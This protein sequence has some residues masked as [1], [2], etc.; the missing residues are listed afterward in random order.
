[1]VVLGLV[2]IGVVALSWGQLPNIGSAGGSSRTA[3]ATVVEQAPCGAKTAGDLVELQQGGQAKRV[4][5]DGCGHMKGQRF[6][7]E[8]SKDGQ[9]AVRLEES[10]TASGLE[11]RV[12]LVLLTLA[13]VAGGGY[14]LLLFRHR[15][16]SRSRPA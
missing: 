10:P 13:G 15:L 9:R 5:L 1:M 16:P 11:G 6:R 4:R 12:T 8:L 2:G 3:M 14:A 7:V